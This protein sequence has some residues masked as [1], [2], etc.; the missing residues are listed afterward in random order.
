ERVEAIE[1]EV[2]AVLGAASY[3]GVEDTFAGVTLAALEARGWKVALAESL[4]AGL[5]ASMLAGVPGAPRLLQ[6]SSV[7]YAR[8]R[9]GRAL[10]GAGGGACPLR[11]GE[12]GLREGQ[13]GGRAEAQGG[14]R[15]RGAHGGGGAGPR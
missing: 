1:R 13:G 5:T 6:G 4:T 15:R 2:R 14:G 7:T 11:R 10:G 9:Q 12:R 3:G 8:A